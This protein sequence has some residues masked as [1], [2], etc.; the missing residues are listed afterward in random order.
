MTKSVE[1]F[2]KTLKKNA[3]EN[4]IRLLEFS[5]SLKTTIITRKND[6]LKKVAKDDQGV[7][8]YEKNRQSILIYGML[9]Q[10]FS[11]FFL[12]LF[13]KR[14]FSYTLVKMK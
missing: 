13:F 8:N 5:D 10:I 2:K 11:L 4:L 7:E 6:T 14:L 1:E 3:R 9:S 12:L